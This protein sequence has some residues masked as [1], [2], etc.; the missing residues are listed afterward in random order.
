MTLKNGSL[1]DA[2]EVLNNCIGT[3][4]KN[5]AQ[6]LYNSAYIGFNSKLNVT[7]APNL[8]NIKYDVFNSDTATTKTGWYYDI[9]NKLYVPSIIDMASE[10]TTHDPD[11]FV[12]P[13]NA[14]DGNSVTMATKTVAGQPALGKTFSSKYVGGVV[15]RAG[16]SVY[17]IGSG[18]KYVG[19]SAV[20]QTYNGST[21]TTVEVI[22]SGGASGIGPSSPVSLPVTT[23]YI[24]INQEIQGIRVFFRNDGTTGNFNFDAVVYLLQYGNAPTTNELI[25]Q[26]TSLPTITDCIATWNASIDPDNTLTVSISADGTNYEEVTDA[27]IH[28]FTDTGTNLFIKFEIDRVN[29]SAIDK[30]SEYAILYNITGDTA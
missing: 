3:P 7:G 17:W 4:F 11:S 20:L 28:R 18:T 1:A 9:G 27:T 30:I 12:N 2:D 8:K 21:W 29:T 22:T 14:F 13:N 26:T 19:G 6:L 23:K 25:F 5:Q 10:D 24:G 15:V 16:G